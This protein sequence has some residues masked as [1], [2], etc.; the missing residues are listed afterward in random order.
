M[1]L[2]LAYVAL[3]CRLKKLQLQLCRT[4]V[5]PWLVRCA[6]VP[7]MTAHA[8]LLRKSPSEQLSALALLTE[9][10]RGAALLQFAVFQAHH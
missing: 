10:L 3:A 5:Q 8:L 1:Q 7:C 9:T 2:C 6:S 4:A